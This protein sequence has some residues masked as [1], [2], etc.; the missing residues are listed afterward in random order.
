MPRQG[1]RLTAKARFLF[2]SLW[3]F[4]AMSPS[5]HTCSSI[6]GWFSSIHRRGL[7]SPEDGVSSQGVECARVIR[8]ER[9]ED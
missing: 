2:V 7:H 4:Y 8:I 3:N 5:E 9:E 1:M 6:S